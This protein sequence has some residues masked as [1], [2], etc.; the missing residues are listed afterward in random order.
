MIKKTIKRLLRNKKIKSRILNFYKIEKNFNENFIYKHFINNN[1]WFFSQ[2]KSGTTKLC[3]TIAFYNAEVMNI[4]NYSFEDIPKLGVG[5]GLMKNFETIEKLI[6]FKIKSNLYYLIQS[7]WPIPDANPKLLIMST[8]NVFDQ[9]ESAYHFFYKNRIRKNKV[10][11]DDA[12]PLLIE[13]Y[14]NT[15]LAQKNIKD[16]FK[17]TIIFDYNEI[18]ENIF[19][20][21]IKILKCL[22]EE[23]NEQKLNKAI[24]NSSL[25]SVSNHEKKYGALKVAR[26]SEF[27]AKSFIR[28]GEI[29]QGEKFFSNKQIEYIEKKLKEKN[30]PTSGNLKDF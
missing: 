25:E 18:K 20:C 11:V 28:S 10:L 22:Y 2:P 1:I 30:I 27:L 26:E 4:K 29:G 16:Q 15:Y 7:H 8:R 24:K 5:R 21:T 19:E 14:S 9:C 6:E 17:S 3:N 23:V 12:L 13:D